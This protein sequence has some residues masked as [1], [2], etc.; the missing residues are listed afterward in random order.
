MRKKH[1]SAPK[2]HTCS[3]PDSR[4][5]QNTGIQDAITN[6]TPVLSPRV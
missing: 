2:T 6:G 5:E 3:G 4:N 1:G